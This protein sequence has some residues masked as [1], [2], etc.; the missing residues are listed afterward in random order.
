M[1]GALLKIMVMMVIDVHLHYPYHS[2]WFEVYMDA[3]DYQ[4]GVV[5]MQ[6]CYLIAYYSK[7]LTSP[8]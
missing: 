1:N 6:N 7:N 2:C 8:Q 3:L 4:L 5:I